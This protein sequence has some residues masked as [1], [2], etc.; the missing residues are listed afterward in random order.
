MEFSPRYEK[1]FMRTSQ[2]FESHPFP[3][4][5]TIIDCFSHA[6]AGK[7]WTIVAA[8]AAIFCVWQRTKHVCKIAV[9]NCLKIEFLVLPPTLFIKLEKKYPL[10]RLK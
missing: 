8:I 1:N 10:H 5:K 6:K 3:N 2:R 9:R 4:L 7:E